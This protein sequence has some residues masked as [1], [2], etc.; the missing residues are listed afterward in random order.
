MIEGEMGVNDSRINGEIGIN[1]ETGI[2]D[3]RI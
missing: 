1:R 3:R 2:N